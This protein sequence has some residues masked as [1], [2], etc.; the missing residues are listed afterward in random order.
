MLTIVSGVFPFLD[1]DR[2][3]STW[4]D[5]ARQLLA[6]GLPVVLYGDPILLKGLEQIPTSST[7]RP[8]SE[9][10][11]RG[12][13]WLHPQLHTVAA[14]SGMSPDQE[15][16]LI[17]RIRSLGWLHDESI[18]NPHS[19]RSFLWLD[20]LLLDEVQPAYLAPGGPLHQIEPLLDPMLLLG[21]EDHPNDEPAFRGTLFGATA[22]SLPAV[23]EAY[24]L[25]YQR[26]LEHGQ[27]P[28]LPLLLAELWRDR[29]G[30]FQR[31]PLQP[32]GLAGAFLEAVQRDVV[33][34][35]TLRA[36]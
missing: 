20:P 15:L 13:I 9:D 5:F 29:P 36:V 24:W 27:L 12:D 32:N 31:F 22:A 1:R 35:E 8:T 6:S 3:E 14:S 18:F 34:L 26:M 21:W 4:L 19:S 10:T 7:L 16:S 2:R 11:L 33:L 17:A 30:S 25:A 23:N 28:T